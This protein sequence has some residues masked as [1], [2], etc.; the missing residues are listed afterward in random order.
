MPTTRTADK[1]LDDLFDYPQAAGDSDKNGDD[2]L[3]VHE[4]APYAPQPRADV[5]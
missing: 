5:R 3:P 1:G 4:Q 2:F